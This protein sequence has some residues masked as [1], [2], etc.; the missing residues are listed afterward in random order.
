MKHHPDTVN[1][2]KFALMKLLGGSVDSS[3]GRFTSGQELACLSQRLALELSSKTYLAVEKER[4]QVERYMRLCLQVD[5]SGETMTTVSPSEPLLAE[6]ASSAMRKMNVPLAMEGVLGGYSIHQGDRGEVLVALLLTLARD[7]VIHYPDNPDYDT[8]IVQTLPL[9]EKLFTQYADIIKV[10]TPT[11][12]PASNRT[13]TF[14]QMLA[15]SAT[16]FNHFVKLQQQGFL[17]DEHLALLIARGAFILCANGDTGVDLIGV[18]LRD[19][20]KPISSSNIIIFLF[21]VKNDAR[22]TRVPKEELFDL[23]DPFALGLVREEDANDVV[24]V[25]VVTALNAIPS[26]TAMP[27]RKTKND[28]FTA[29]DI[30]CSGMS[31]KVYAPIQENQGNTWDALLSASHGWKKLYEGKE[32]ATSLRRQENA[33]AAADTAHWSN[34]A[35]PPPKRTSKKK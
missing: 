7:A 28:K 29:Y 10:M 5:D 13:K 21:Q 25:R 31:H 19:K 24:V 6:V 20:A 34:W 22:Y 16:H 2:R 35:T 14:E 4:E 11:L 12:S 27:R 3:E 17:T 9:F 23:M 15:K 8:P 18:A 32:T 33:S 1:L 26:I 30:W